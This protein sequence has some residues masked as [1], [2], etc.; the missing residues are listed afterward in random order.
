MHCFEAAMAAAA[1]LEHH[2]Y[3]P[4]V[5]SLE[6]KDGLDHVIYVFKEKTGWG[7]ITRSRD[8]GLHGRAP[9][10]HSLRDLAWS[11]Y[12]P[13]VDKTGKITAYQVAH[14]DDCG[15]NWRSSVKNVWKAEQYLIDLKHIP[16]KSSKSRYKK[17]H[18]DYLE[19]GPIP[20]QKNWW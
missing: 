5:M 20:R 3:P 2:G 7:A 16:L 19:Q 18:K 1:I 9:R 14:M 13:Y 11:Y 6:S 12:D 10:Y 8:E 17:L 4:L 15:T